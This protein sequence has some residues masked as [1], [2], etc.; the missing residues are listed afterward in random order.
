MSVAD[1]TRFHVILSL[2]GMV[3]GIVV[4]LAMLRAHVLPVMTSIFL[5]TTMA[6]SVTGF[7]FPIAAFGPPEIVGV[8]SIIILGL[9]MLA[10]YVY[11]LAGSWRMI[12]VVSAVLALYLNVFVGVVQAFQKVPFFHALAPTQKEAP[13]AIAQAAVLL[14]FAALGAAAAKKF[15]PLGRPPAFA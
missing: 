12:Y 5:T 4:V 11:R 14:V 6:T 1:F 8:I 2:V 3:S 10:L 9:A 15:R 7:L 13:F